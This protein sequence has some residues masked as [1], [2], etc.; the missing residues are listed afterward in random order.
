MR[1]SV[2]AVRE[3]RQ[4]A[5]RLRVRASQRR[6]PP[7]C[8]AVMTRVRR[9][10]R[11]VSSI[12]PPA[13]RWMGPGAT[14]SMSHY[15]LCNHPNLLHKIWTATMISKGLATP[16]HESESY[17]WIKPGKSCARIVRLSSLYSQESRRILSFPVA[18]M[19]RLT[20]PDIRHAKAS[21]LQ[22]TSTPR[23]ASADRSPGPAPAPS[24][25]GTRRAAGRLWT[26]PRSARRPERRRPSGRGGF[27]RDAPAGTEGQATLAATSLPGRDPPSLLRGGWDPD[28]R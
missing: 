5:L 11:W 19:E 3:T 24:G 27:L 7:H 18:A 12:A 20:H 17:L 13:Y 9:R 1:G 25:R 2:R 22:K 26:L 14:S 21:V 8:H 4:Q 23:C 10:H 28:R 15:M 6:Q 16:H